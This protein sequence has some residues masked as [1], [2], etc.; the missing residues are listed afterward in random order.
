[1]LSG[2]PEPMTVPS[3][4]VLTYNIHK[5]FD[6]YNRDFVLHGIR[7]QLHSVDADI[8]FL[9]EIIGQHQR[10][11]R[12]VL[13][14]PTSAQFDFLAEHL[15]PHVAYGKN[16]LYTGGHHGNAILSKYQLQSWQNINLS[17]W[18]QASRSLL[19]GVIHIPESGLPL[20]LI[21][22][23]LELVAFERRR[24]VRVLKQY[25]KEV[26]P[27][28][29]P[30]IIAGDF[31]DWNQ[32]LGRR[33]EADLGLQEAFE[34][35]HGRYARTYPVSWP[36]LSMDRIYFRN[37]SFIECACLDTQPWKSLSDHAPLYAQLGYAS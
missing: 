34:Y 26:I 28:D 22:I 25:I 31:N 11:E 13:N 24:Q 27:E 8:V 10:H 29:E 6:L 32:Q 16:A 37:L 19:H 4:K 14:W 20:H 18:R 21:C 12:Q 2:N 9:Q 1:V 23:H 15:W 5:G 36:V 17:R 30:M 33:L 35:T 3:L 7:E